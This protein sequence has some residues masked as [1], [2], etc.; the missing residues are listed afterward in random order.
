MSL[1]LYI[2]N[3]NVI[4]LSS[5]KNF[6]TDAYINDATVTA[7]L[8]DTDDVEVVGQTWPLTLA[9]AAATDGI[10]RGVLEYDLS[11]DIAGSMYIA[12]VDVDAGSGLIAHFEARVMAVTRR[13]T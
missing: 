6:I 8:Y 10:Y 4:E 11:V 7:T 13:T 9:Y 3:D 1:T 12:K 2:D 5:L